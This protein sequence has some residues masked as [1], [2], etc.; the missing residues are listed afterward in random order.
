[1]DRV[2]YNAV[3]VESVRPRHA[4]QSQQ[5]LRSVSRTHNDQ[6]SSGPVVCCLATA[7]YFVGPED[8]MLKHDR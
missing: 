7:V 3:I 4:V 2:S 8:G 5:W 6:S 1:M